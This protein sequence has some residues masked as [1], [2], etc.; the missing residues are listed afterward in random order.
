MKIDQSSQS[1]IKSIERR[2]RTIELPRASVFFVLERVL[3]SCAGVF[4]R[5]S[6]FYFVSIELPMWNYRRGRGQKAEKN[7]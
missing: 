6:G 7:L 1:N 2:D 3:L 4:F 5:F